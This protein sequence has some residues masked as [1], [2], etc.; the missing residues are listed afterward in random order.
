[1]RTDEEKGTPEK[2]DG[3][4]AQTLLRC[5]TR[6]AVLLAGQP[7]SANQTRQTEPAPALGQEMF[8]EAAAAKRERK[9]R[10]SIS[11]RGGRGAD[12]GAIRESP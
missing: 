4:S 3:T 2:D 12:G 11:A 8:W 5:A 1:M 7:G 10:A 9:S 6:E